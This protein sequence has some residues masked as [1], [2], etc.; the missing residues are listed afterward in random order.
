MSRHGRHTP[1]ALAHDQ[2]IRDDTAPDDRVVA[3]KL[4]VEAMLECGVPLVRARVMWSA[5]CLATRASTRPWGLVGILLWGLLTLVGGVLLVHGVLTGSWYEV[6]LA[7][8]A[9]FGAALL[10]GRQWLAG[11]IAG[12]ALWFV[13][14][15][16]IA[17]FLG[18]AAYWV[19]ETIVRLVR[20]L[21]RSMRPGPAPA[22]PAPP[23]PVPY[24]A[25]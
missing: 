2:L 23:A 14:G 8:I 10:W 11:V 18:Y 22:L 4:F 25:L 19:V 12:L 13:A 1:A 15:P 16:A 21:G 7:L 20:M 5:V 17:S 3:D 6:G 9:P 24:K